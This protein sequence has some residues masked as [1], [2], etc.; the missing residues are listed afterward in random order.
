MKRV[1]LLLAIISIKVLLSKGLALAFIVLS[2]MIKGRALHKSEV[3]WN[4]YF[5]LIDEKSMFKYIMYIYTITTILSSSVMFLLF[6]VFDFQCSLL[7]TTIILTLCIFFAWLKYQKKGR[8]ELIKQFIKL[9]K[10]IIT[11]NSDKNN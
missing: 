6:K 5:L 8:K 3:E 10:N 2:F 7:L 11:E 9:Q 1:L 4:K